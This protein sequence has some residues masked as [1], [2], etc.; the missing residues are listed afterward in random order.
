VSMMFFIGVLI[1]MIMSMKKHARSGHTVNNNHF[2][3]HQ[4]T[5]TKRKR[6][7]SRKQRKMN[8]GSHI[9]KYVA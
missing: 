5:G 2:T 1:D 3:G 7:S 9:N 6:G 8:Q 4:K